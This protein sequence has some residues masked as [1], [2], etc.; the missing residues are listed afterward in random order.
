MDVAQGSPFGTAVLSEEQLSDSE[1]S[2]SVLYVESSAGDER[3]WSET[4]VSRPSE[5]YMQPTS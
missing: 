4:R 1:E 3:V 2:A 5:G